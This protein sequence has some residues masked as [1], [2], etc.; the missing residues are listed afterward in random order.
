MS[1]Y[2]IRPPALADTTPLVPG[3]PAGLD[4]A[5]LTALAQHHRWSLVVLFGSVAR[6]GRG[7][8]LDLAVLPAQVPDLLEQG[9]WHA[10][11]EALAAPRPVDLLLIQASLS[12]VTRFE[13]FR[14]GVCL[15][16]AEPGLFDRERDRAFFLYAD[17]EWFR[18][19]QREVLYG[20][21]H[22]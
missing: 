6:A 14:A 8:D 4:R 20:T 16:E 11:L 1:R 3:L 19:Q 18:H 13:V 15:F 7:R 9:R 5:G 12:T 10:E 2:P 17:G 21:G 22:D